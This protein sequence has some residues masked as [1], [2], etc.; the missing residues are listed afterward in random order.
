[1]SFE[2]MGNP[3]IRCWHTRGRK[4]ESGMGGRGLVIRFILFCFKKA[5]EKCFC[6]FYKRNEAGM[7]RGPFF[8]KKKGMV[9]TEGER[10]YDAGK[11]EG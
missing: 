9:K 6:F 11:H 7:R 2:G 8:L 5:D 10:V 4:K 3:E 1:M